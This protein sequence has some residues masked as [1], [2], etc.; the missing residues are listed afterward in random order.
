MDPDTGAISTSKLQENMSWRV[1]SPSKWLSLWRN[2]YKSL[3]WGRFFRATGDT[4]ETP[5]LLEGFSCEEKKL[6]S[7]DPTL[8]AEFQMIWKIRA[9]H[10]VSGLPS[11]MFFLLCCYKEDCPHPRCRTGPHPGTLSWYPGG[12][13][14]L[15]SQCQFLIL[16]DC[17]ETA[18]VQAAKDFALATTRPC[19]WM[20]LTVVQFQ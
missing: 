5:Y 16:N 8:F 4:W 3:S 7:Q 6:Q 9:N 10:M 19:L 14:I 13:P 15:I 20:L 17:G 1:H 18:I 2:S 11:Y 12:P